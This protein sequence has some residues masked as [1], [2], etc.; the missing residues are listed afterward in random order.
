VKPANG[1]IWMWN[2]W[3]GVVLFPFA[4]E[5]SQ[6]VIVATRMIFNRPL[7]SIEDMQVD[8]LIDYRIA[9]HVG[10]TSYNKRGDTG[11]IIA[12]DINFIF[13]LGKKRTEKNSLYLTETTFPLLPESMRRL[14]VEE[15]S[16]EGRGL[17]RMRKPLF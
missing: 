14:F 1:E 3:G 6:P 12:D 10:N 13:H 2:E 8:T 5:N 15:E 9:L 16:F 4:Y 7:I 11:E 17:Y